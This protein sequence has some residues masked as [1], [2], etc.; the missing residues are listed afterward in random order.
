MI[1][2]SIVEEAVR[3]KSQTEKKKTPRQKGKVKDRPKNLQNA[4]TKERREL[5][6]LMVR[7]YVTHS[8]SNVAC[9]QIPK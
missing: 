3:T 5:I 7:S 9:M 4:G 8:P 6:P 1:S 2:F